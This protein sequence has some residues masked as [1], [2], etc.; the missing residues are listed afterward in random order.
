M[1][2]SCKSKKLSPLSLMGSKYISGY[3]ERNFRILQNF[4]L[5]CDS[6]TKDD[7]AYLAENFNILSL[8]MGYPSPEFKEA[9]F[10]TYSLINKNWNDYSVC[11]LI[12]NEPF[13]KK[14][15][16]DFLSVTEDFFDQNLSIYVYRYYRRL[17]AILFTN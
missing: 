12:Y 1:N 9:N 3:G 11:V 13:L 6:N 17:S 14:I 15:T 5:F 10:D 8:M 7:A 4:T 2:R 16:Y